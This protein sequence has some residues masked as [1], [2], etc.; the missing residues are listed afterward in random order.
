M[1]VFSAIVPP[2]PLLIPS[3]GKE[4]AAA[5]AHTIDALAHIKS[6][7]HAIHPDAC[8]IISQYS[9][10]PQ[11]FGI[12]IHTHYKGSLKDFGDLREYAA[13]GLP[14]LGTALLT[15]IPHGMAAGVTLPS[16]DY[17]SVVALRSLCG[18]APSAPVV[19]LHSCA[20][21]YEAHARFGAA[22]AE[23]VIHSSHR[24][25][26]I[27]VADL[28]H[29]ATEASPEGYRAEGV[30]FDKAVRGALQKKS[31]RHLMETARK[32][33]EEAALSGIRAMIILSGILEDFRASFRLLAY[34]SPFGVSYL[35]AEYV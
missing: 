6:S 22:L 26:L 28:S 21:S 15:Q 25:A 11:R 35:T 10:L 20:A 33:D 4:H 7:L 8:I 17:A 19:P 14:S 31:T 24:I 34:E 5:L 18:D 23:P 1:I 30:L 13:P 2:S 12:G 27:A 16:L 32:Y 9:R 29:H 3:I